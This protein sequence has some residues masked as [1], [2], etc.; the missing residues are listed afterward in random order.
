MKKEYYSTFLNGLEEPV[1]G[2]LHKT[3]GISVTRMLKGAAVYRSVREPH[4]SCMQRT[5]QILC[6]MRPEKDLNAAL[7]RLSA[8]DS[9]LDRFDFESIAGMRFRIVTAVDGQPSAGDMRYVAMLEKSICEQTGM[10]VARERPQVE[11]WVNLR[12]EAL[13]FLWRMNKKE[14]Q[15]N[16]DPLRRDLCETMAA[17]ARPQGGQTVILGLTGPNLPDALRAQGAASVGAVLAGHLKSGAA[18]GY[19]TVRILSGTPGCTGLEAGTMDAVF[20]ALAPKGNFSIQEE[21]LRGTL[22]EAM[23]IGKRNG[24]L[25]VF[26]PRSLGQPFRRLYEQERLFSYQVTVSGEECRLEGF[27]IPEEPLS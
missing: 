6:E 16:E 4:L 17:L 15:K 19:G 26:Y 27:R 23:R 14:G 2:I 7:R 1:E 8:T 18:K 10:L 24:R 9:W 11:L 13:Y 20:V 22:R 12:Q 25:V 3:G 5:Y 21:D